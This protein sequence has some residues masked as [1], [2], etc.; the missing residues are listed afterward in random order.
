MKLFSL[1]VIFAFISTCLLAHDDATAQKTVFQM[2]KVQTDS[3]KIESSEA[4][5]PD[6]YKINLSFRIEPVD[7]CEENYVGLF[8]SPYNSSDFTAIYSKVGGSPCLQSGSPRMVSHF[9]NLYLNRKAV[10]ISLNG[11]SLT[12]YKNDQD[13]ILLEEGTKA[14]Q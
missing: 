7:G 8:K 4:A 11:K 13:Q 1:A 3:I 5:G 6:W 10:T 9:L 14:A 12:I 2:V